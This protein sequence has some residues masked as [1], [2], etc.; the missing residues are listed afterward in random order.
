MI[1]LLHEYVISF[2]FLNIKSVHRESFDK[3]VN[4]KV[5]GYSDGLDKLEGLHKAALVFF[6]NNGL[7]KAVEPPSIFI[8]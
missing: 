2:T 4:S 6:H 8:I 5:E 1:I 3:L 7:Q